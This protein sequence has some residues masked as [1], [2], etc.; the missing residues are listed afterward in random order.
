[1]QQDILVQDSRVNAV[2]N[3]EQGDTRDVLDNVLDGAI[4]IKIDCASS[5]IS[6]MSET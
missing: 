2:R 1:M 6:L 4:G 5:Y 3:R